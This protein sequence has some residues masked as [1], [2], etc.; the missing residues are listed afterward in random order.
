MPQAPAWR[1]VATNTTH[2]FRTINLHGDSVYLLGE[3]SV[4]QRRADGTW[5]EPI[6]IPGERWADMVVAGPQLFFGVT[7]AQGNVRRWRT[8]VMSEVGR[9]GSCA[10]T[11]LRM[12][13]F[14]ETIAA[15]CPGGGG[16]AFWERGPQ[17]NFSEQAGVSP[18]AV[19]LIAEYDAVFL[20][21]EGLRR[22]RAGA[23]KPAT[24]AKAPAGHT[25]LWATRNNI[26]SASPAGEFAHWGWD[27]ATGV[28]GPPMML[29]APGAVAL[30]ALWG[31]NADDIYAVGAGG[32][33]LNFDGFSWR[34]VAVPTKAP[35]TCM[36]GA[37]GTLW[38]AGATG[39]LLQNRV[40]EF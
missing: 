21:A 26:V 19:V 30:H 13:S 3:G 37:F 20:D 29:K 28:P 38:I 40:R 14:G 22:M 2:N 18:R 4:H 17:H 33:V 7:E 11:D 31:L 39:T 25:L 6:V 9:L 35:L 24:I 10:S 12:A 32:V 27:S 5:A 16:F 1:V 23:K 15:G 34:S 8:G 36:T